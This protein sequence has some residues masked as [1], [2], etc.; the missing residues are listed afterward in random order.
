[1]TMLNLSSRRCVRLSPSLASF[2]ASFFIFHAI[3]VIVTMRALACS[4]IWPA[5][6]CGFPGGLV[7]KVGKNP[8]NTIT[9]FGH[10][11]FLNAVAMI[12]AEK[13]WNADDAT[14]KALSE[15][16]LGESEG[17]ILTKTAS[18]MTM[19]HMKC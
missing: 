11:V 8:G 10:A 9:S 1:M 19:T 17:I 3:L 6:A 18:G 16:D 12:V 4:M 5:C 13:V 15:L 2:L 14:I 7:G